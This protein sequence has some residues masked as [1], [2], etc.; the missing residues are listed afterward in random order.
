MDDYKFMR[1]MNTGET[2]LFNVAED[3][4][5][6]NDLSKSLPEKSA[7]ME[8][9]LLDYI[10]EVDG[11]DVKE[12][13]AAYLRWIDENEAKVTTENHERQTRKTRKK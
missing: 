7:E 8:R 6:Q 13:Y 1:H 3:Y 2:K 11:G 4:S 5:E 10:K 9:V 12:V